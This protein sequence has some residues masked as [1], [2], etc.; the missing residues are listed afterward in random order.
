MNKTWQL[1]SL[2]GHKVF[3]TPSFLIVC[4]VLAFWGVNSLSG[5][6]SGA[7]IIPVLFVG[8]L[9]H[10]L[11]HAAASKRFGYGHSEIMFWGLGGVAINRYR[12]RRNNKHNIAISLAGP[13][14]SALL[15]IASGGALYA[16]TGALSSGSTLL[17]EFLYLMMTLNIFWAV[18][19]LL[20]IHPM[21]GGQAML[22]GLKIAL[23]DT[24]KAIKMT[25]YISFAAIALGLGAYSL[26]LGRVDVTIGLFGAYFAY[27]NYKMLRE[28]REVRMM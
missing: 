17:G 22:S 26:L 18:F 16:Y 12:G 27:M 24:Q 10:E 13:A 6:L 25:A 11:G 23:K 2:F 4:A 3:L 1:F 20:P 21:D 9:L 28:G 14:V 8:I 5:L 15:G 7:L 19:N